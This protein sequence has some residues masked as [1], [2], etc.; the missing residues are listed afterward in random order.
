VTG[1]TTTDCHACARSGPDHGGRCG[2]W[3][4]QSE[5]MRLH[6]DGHDDQGRPVEAT[7]R[8]SGNWDIGI[9]GQYVGT[10]WYS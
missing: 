4:D 3:A 7:Y 10:V 8:S 5:L 2:P 9:D 6:R 1:R